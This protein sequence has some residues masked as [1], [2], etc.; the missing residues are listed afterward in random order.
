MKN[1]RI[2]ICI[3]LQHEIEHAMEVFFEKVDNDLFEYSYIHFKNIQEYF[4]NIRESE[5]PSF[6]V[7]NFCE[8]SNEED[9]IHE[10]INLL[11][12]YTKFSSIPIIGI[13]DNAEAIEQSA[14]LFGV[15][16]NYAHILGNDSQQF[17]SNIYYISFEDD[18]YNK[19]Y[20][21]AKGYTIDFTLQSLVYLSSIS[22]ET[23]TFDSDITVKKDNIDAE[24]KLFDDFG[25]LSLPIIESFKGGK[26]FNT[27]F[28]DLLKIPFSSD[29]DESEGL[30]TD[31][32]ETWFDMNKEDFSTRSNNILF[33]TKDLA[34]FS[35]TFEMLKSHKSITFTL[36][37]EF[38]SKDKEILK[39][40]PQF[41]FYQIVT[42]EDYDKMD[43]FLTELSN[44]QPQYSPIVLLFNCNS[45]STA[46]QKLYNLKTLLSSPKI[47]DIENL[48]NMLTLLDKK[49]KK[50]NDYLFKNDSRVVSYYNLDIKVT[51]ITE[52]EITFQSYVEIPMYSIVKISIPISMYMVIIPPFRNLRPLPDGFHYQAFVMGISEQ[53]SEY[54]RKYVNHLI[55]HKPTTWEKVSFSDEASPLNPQIEAEEED[56]NLNRPATE[57]EDKDEIPLKEERLKTK[58]LKSKL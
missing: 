17:L 50:M 41:I 54:L 39:L 51:S 23:L 42:E 25:T 28:S 45:S 2:I 3:G 35:T 30:S 43:E 5:T 36:R 31:T 4:S 12:G 29:W 47:P 20:A 8:I 44:F 40:K 6:I 9:I 11:K 56:T 32:Y 18:S 19:D 53:S 52:N 48:N 14:C 16:V 58:T 21:I 38:N 7:M 22:E 55:S 24:I 33:F 10:T 1:K 57:N 37:E 15:G 49:S 34:I 13:F 27:F 46:L 26:I